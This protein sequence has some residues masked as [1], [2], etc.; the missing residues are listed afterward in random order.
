MDRVAYGDA[1]GCWEGTTS[2]ATPALDGSAERIG[3]R[4]DTDNNVADFVFRTTAN[5]QNSS[6]IDDFDGDGRLDNVDNCPAVANAG[7]EDTDRD[8]LGDA[9]DPD[10]DNDGLPDG[11]DACPKVAAATAPR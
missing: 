6:T 9:C 4:Q 7:Q 8:G 1:A 3:G 2:I 10:D 11:S 5:P